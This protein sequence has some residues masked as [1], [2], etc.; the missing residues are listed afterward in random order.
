MPRSTTPS[1]YYLGLVLVCSAGAWLPATVR[2]GESLDSLMY[3]HPEFPTPQVVRTWSNKLP[4]LWLQALDRPE[5]DLRCRAALTIAKA[6][7]EGMPGLEVTIPALRRE[8]SRT[9]QHHSVRVSVARALITLDA[10]DA[11]PE[12]FKW[13]S[14]ADDDYREVSELALARWGYGPA[15]EDWLQRLAQSEPSGR[16]FILSIQALAILNEERASPRLRELV[17]SP[18]IS[19]AVRHEAARALGTLRQAGGE[20][21]AG[22]LTRDQSPQGLTS[23]LAAVNLLRKHSGNEAVLRLQL[24][25]RDKEPSIVAIAVKRLL[26]IDPGLVEPDLASVLASPDANVRTLGIEVLSRRSSAESERLLAD[27][28]SDPHPDVRALARRVLL[29]HAKSPELTAVVI[30]EGRR[31]LGRTDWRGQEQA[32]LLLVKLDHKPA[33][34]RLVELLADSRA[35]VAITAAWGLRVLAV[36][37]TLPKVL[38]YFRDHSSTSP[39][40]GTKLNALELD[41]QLSHLAQL[42]GERRYGPADRVLRSLIRPRTPA[43]I[44]TR[45]AACWALGLLHEGKDDPELTRAFTGRID[46]LSRLPP[47]DRRVTRM[48]AI[49]LGRMK[50]KEG[51]PNLRK[52]Y[53]EGKYSF[54]GFNNACGWAIEQITGEKVPPPGTQYLPQVQWFLVPLDP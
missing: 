50:A 17:L 37:A 22:Q 39:T 31:V 8:L 38:D 40:G 18:A 14:S 5:V 53:L 30:A 49:A 34:D 7:E 1:R 42:L 54:D 44:E 25:A 26:E 41:Q 11:A 36:P 10:R 15:R 52:Y 29:E 48:C 46:A 43:L 20:A 35:E 4:G 24:L 45:A 16:R 23:R 9:D 2:A 28:L 47:E 12:L 21:D 19:A 32:A 13:I 33:A 51:L 3:H 27:R 6:H